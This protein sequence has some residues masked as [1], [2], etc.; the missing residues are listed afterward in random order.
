[1]EILQTDHAVMTPYEVLQVVTKRLRYSKPYRTG[2]DHEHLSDDNFRRVKIARENMIPSLIALSPEGTEED[3]NDKIG[4]KIPAFCDELHNLE[5]NIT[6]FQMRNILCVRPRN[7]SELACIFPT[8]EE[9][10]VVANVSEDI[11]S[12]VESYF[13]VY[14]PAPVTNTAA[15]ESE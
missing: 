5:P 4:E 6:P 12:L 9:W 2:R 3:G 1:M 13:P 11:V 10:G 7:L 15:E 14:E 8:Q